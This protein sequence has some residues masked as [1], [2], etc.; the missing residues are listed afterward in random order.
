MALDKNNSTKLVKWPDGLPILE[1][2]GGV[3]VVAAATFTA[4]ARNRKNHISL[5]NAGTSFTIATATTFVSD[6]DDTTYN[7]L[8]FAGDELILHVPEAQAGVLTITFGAGF[9]TADAQVFA[10]GDEYV[11]TFEY[12]TWSGVSGYLMKSKVLVVT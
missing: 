2:N 4:I 9:I 6:P 8:R 3:D 10:S 5:T 7:I 12:G 1:D 11:L